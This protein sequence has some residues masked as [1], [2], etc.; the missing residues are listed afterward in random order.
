MKKILVV[1]L[2]L[3][4]GSCVFLTGAVVRLSPGVTDVYVTLSVEAAKCKIST[5]KPAW[6]LP[7][8]GRPYAKV[9]DFVHWPVKAQG[10][11]CKHQTIYIA[12]GPNDFKTCGPNP[13]PTDNPFSTCSDPANT[14]ELLKDKH[15]YCAVSRQAKYGCYKYSFGGDVPL[16][17]EIE[18]GGPPN[19]LKAWWESLQMLFGTGRYSS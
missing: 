17:P 8:T 16:D 3:A 13:Q 12:D 9:G 14:G 15:L 7:S 11:E 5:I 1:L 4:I 18:I 19:N 10:H 6:P 2:L